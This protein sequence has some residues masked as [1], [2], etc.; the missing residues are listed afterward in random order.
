MSPPSSSICVARNWSSASRPTSIFTVNGWNRSRDLRFLSAP[1]AWPRAR[2]IS[3]WDRDSIVASREMTS[4]HC[5]LQNAGVSVTSYDGRESTRTRRFRSRMSPRSAGCRSSFTKLSSAFSLY[6]SPR[7]I[8]S[9]YSRPRSTTN[10][11][12]MTPVAQ[13]SRGLKS[14]CAA[15]GALGGMSDIL[16]HVLAEEPR[17]LAVEQRVD[18]LEPERHGRG[19]RPRE[20]RLEEHARDEH[21]AGARLGRDGGAQEDRRA[22]GEDERAEAREERERGAAPHVD[23]GGDR[24]DGE[25]EHHREERHEPLRRARHEVH[26]VADPGRRDGPV[27]VAAV[28]AEVGEWLHGSFPGAN[29]AGRTSA[30]RSQL[31]TTSTSSSRVTSTAGTTRAS[32]KRPCCLRS[33]CVTFPTGSPRGKTPSVPEVTSGSPSIMS[34][35]RSA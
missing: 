5:F 9:W 3:S 25:E 32:W 12:M 22:D 31:V 24:A 19:E 34:S 15:P 29:A 27:H 17:L 18:P 14:F 16:E 26:D 8:W 6:S 4:S 13:K 21:R 33:N 1:F 10:E 20:E 30:G 11:R 7:R 2:S 28:Q 23:R 35:V